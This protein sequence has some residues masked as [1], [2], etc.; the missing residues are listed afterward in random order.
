MSVKRILVPAALL[1]VLA[2]PPDAAA[3]GSYSLPVSAVVLA[4]SNCRFQAPRAATM[5]FGNLDSGNPVNVTMDATLTFR[6]NGGIQN[7]VFSISDDGGMNDPV[8]GDRKMVHET[9]AAYTL[10]YS[11]VF[12]PS[13]GTVPRNT[14]QTLTIRGTVQGTD[15]A[16]VLPGNYSDTVVVTIVP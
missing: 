14:N 7:V 10:P 2:A 3:G 13:S 6:C 4:S 12:S 5:N 16:T 8:P 1:L 9:D 15:Y 11:L